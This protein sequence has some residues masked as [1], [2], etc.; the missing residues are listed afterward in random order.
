MDFTIDRFSSEIET[1][2]QALDYPATA[3]G[4]YEPVKYTLA[5]GGKR[6]RPVL[7]IAACA[8]LAH[9]DGTEAIHQALAVELFHNFTLLHDDV[10]DNADVR[11]GRPTVHHRW[12]VNAAILSGDAMVSMA[13]EQL[14]TDAG[15]ELA[16]LLKCFNTTAMEVYQGQQLDMEFE[17]RKYVSVDEYLHMIGLKTSVLLGCAC[18]LGAIRAKADEH[19]AQAMYDYGFA[20]GMAFQ[21]RDDWL[22]TFGD[23][24]VFGKEIGGDIVNGKKTWLLIK[25]REVDEMR[26]QAL[27]ADSCMPQELIEKVSEIYRRHGLDE[28]CRRLAEDYAA[29]A[30]AIIATVDIDKRACDFFCSL[31]DHACTRQH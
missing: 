26:I 29:R 22:D 20:L 21:L 19:T 30:K 8:A 7:T 28:G 9:T 2:L 6:L 16:D 10:M 5:S 13:I 17:E 12:G 11:R 18:R 24:A 31:A 14:A 3:P 23:P 4:L 15:A 25:A 27:Y 1:V